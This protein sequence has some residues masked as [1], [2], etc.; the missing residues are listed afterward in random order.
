WIPGNSYP[1]AV[2]SL[3][4]AGPNGWW[5]GVPVSPVPAGQ[6]Q[7]GLGVPVPTPQPQHLW[8]PAQAQPA[9][10]PAAPAKPV[11]PPDGV[12]QLPDGQLVSGP[13]GGAVYVIR[14]G[15]KQHIPDPATFRNSGFDSANILSLPA[16]ALALIPEGEPL[17]SAMF[18]DR[19]PDAQLTR[20]A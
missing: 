16:S 9:P 20:A 17:R 10:P 8:S 1:D 3:I 6:L 11:A 5:A 4:A 19:K 13:S 14:N 7:D 18:Y 12:P 15:R 2:L